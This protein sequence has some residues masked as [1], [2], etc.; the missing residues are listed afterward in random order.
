MV[1]IFWKA[2]GLITTPF[3]PDW[4]DGGPYTPIIAA[5]LM[6]PDNAFKITKGQRKFGADSWF[7]AQADNLSLSNKSGGSIE[8]SFDAQPDKEPHAQTTLP[9][10]GGAQRQ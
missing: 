8:G 1:Y 9:V 7:A 4:K 10:V 3:L 6:S 5:K 2:Q